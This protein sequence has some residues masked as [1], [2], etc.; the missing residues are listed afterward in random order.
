MESLR[1][2]RKSKMKK[3]RDEFETVRRNII[4]ASVSSSKAYKKR[5]TLIENR[6]VTRRALKT[7]TRTEMNKIK[8]SLNKSKTYMNKNTC[9]GS[10]VESSQMIYEKRLSSREDFKDKWSEKTK[11]EEWKKTKE[12]S[13]TTRKTTRTQRI[14][15]AETKTASRTT[16]QDV[17]Q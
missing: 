10:K 9:P 15:T 14:K 11:S 7:A 6:K 3:Y 13:T 4:L 16:T 2:Q 12:T 17:L 8:R 5:Q 1:T